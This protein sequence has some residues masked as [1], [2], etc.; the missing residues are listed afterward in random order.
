[1]LKYIKIWI[2]YLFIILF[3]ILFIK[4]FLTIPKYIN[5]LVL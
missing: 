4:Y 5:E 2:L 3:N 1:M